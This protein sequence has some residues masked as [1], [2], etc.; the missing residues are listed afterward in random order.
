MNVVHFKQHIASRKHEPVALQVKESQISIPPEYDQCQFKF[1]KN[2]VSGPC[3]LQEATVTACDLDGDRQWIQLSFDNDFRSAEFA[4]WLSETKKTLIDGLGEKLPIHAVGD[5]SGDTLLLS[6]FRRDYTGKQKVP[7]RKWKMD[8]QGVLQP[9]ESCVSVGTVVICSFDE[10]RA[11]SKNDQVKVVGDLNRDLVVVRKS[12]KR[13][14]TI[15]YFS[16]NE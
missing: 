8:R 4:K 9:Y 1:K 7:I 5:A 6:R 14:R 11:Y 12:N 3:S 2:K 15:Q 16:D 10:L 13:R